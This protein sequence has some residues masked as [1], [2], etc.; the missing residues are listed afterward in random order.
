[1]KMEQNTGNINDAAATGATKTLTA[2][3]FCKAVHFTVTVA[4]SDLPLPVHLCSCSICRYTHGMMSTFHA[5]LPRGVSPRFIAPSTLE[6][7][8]TGYTFKSDGGGAR[9]MSSRFF[10]KTCGCHVGDRDLEPNADGDFEWR[11]ASSVFDDHGPQAFRIESH[12]YADPATQGTGGMLEWLPAVGDRV[13][14]T[15]NPEAPG[16]SAPP[17]PPPPPEQ[18][19]DE[20]GNERL[21]V[22]CHC[23][24]VSFTL[25]RPS[26]AATADDDHLRHFASPPDASKWTASLD[27][28]DDCRLM[29]GAHVVAWTYVPLAQT[30]P[31][32][33][34]DF[35]FGTLT[36]YDSTPGGEVKRAF[37]GVCG[38]T[39]FFSCR[40]RSPEDRPDRHVVDVAVGPLR[41]PEG[42]A[43]ERWLSWRCGRISYLDSGRRYDAAFADSLKKGYEAWGR[44]LYGKVLDWPLG[45]PESPL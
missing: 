1:M 9:A 22:Q 15:W 39:V 3:C 6:G 37:C 43:A 33:P 7:A 36:A 42:I 8:L 13:L 10:C 20:A 4:L 31:R 16:T 27:L 32:V 24:G 11:V 34:P 40:S 23:G 45:P 18:E 29:D 2:R 17:P 35:R 26:A 38:A 28:C 19:F 44:K 12:V 30:L 25:P 21:R 41:A 14:K 5:P